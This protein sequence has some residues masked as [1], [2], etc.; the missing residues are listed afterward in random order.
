MPCTNAE[1]SAA[2]GQCMRRPALLPM[3]EAAVR[4]FGADAVVGLVASE[5]RLITGA[6]IAVDGGI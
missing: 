4:L 2:L 3:P 6:K 1:L 5:N